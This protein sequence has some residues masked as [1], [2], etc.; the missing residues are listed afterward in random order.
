M[1]RIPIYESQVMPAG[2]PG[3][4]PQVQVI[5]TMAPAYEAGQDVLRRLDYAVQRKDEQDAVA[6]S[7]LATAETTQE[8]TK[9]ML[10]RQ[11]A[12]EPGAPNFVPQLMSDYDAW[13]EQKLEAAPNDRAR[14]AFRVRAMNLKSGLLEDGMRFQAQAGVALRRAQAQEA[15]TLYANSLVSAPGQFEAVMEEA[16]D[17]IQALDLSPIERDAMLR[18]ARG[19]LAQS[20]VAGL[21]QADPAA[22]LR[23]L[24][25]GA[26]DSYLDPGKKVAMMNAATAEM[27][28][29][30]AQARAEAA[31]ARAEFMASFQD[32]LAFLSAGGE[33]TAPT[34]YD[35][36]T[37][38]RVLGAERGRQAADAYDRALQVG[39]LR[40]DVDAMPQA[41]LD[42]LVRGLQAELMGA[43][44]EDF[45]AR[46]AH[47]ATLLNLAGERYK[48]LAADQ[49]ELASAIQAEDEAYLQRL[50]NEIDF[51]AAGGQL[52]ETEFSRQS[53]VTR[54]GDE[55]GGQ[56]ADHRDWVA[57]TAGR[58]GALAGAA[59]EEAQTAVV[60][61]RSTLLAGPQAFG[62]RSKELAAIEEAY[63]RRQKDLAA[64]PGGYA[65]RVNPAVRAAYDA[66]VAAMGDP[67]ADG[68]A[69]AERYAVV[70]SE[71][72]RRLTGQE[73]TAILP[74]AYVQNVALQFA[75]Q[76]EGGENAAQLVQG[77]QATWGKRWP[78]VYGQLVQEG[79]LPP[80]A[81]VIGSGVP[82]ATA[83]RLA[84]AS[85]LS[86]PE[87]KKGLLS[88]D[89]TALTDE[90]VSRME[91]FRLL[92]SNYAGGDAAFGPYYSAVELLGYSYMRQGSS[93]S[94]A[95]RRA[96]NELIGDRYALYDTYFVP[97]DE[98]PEEVIPSG[99]AA[100]QRDLSAW[101]PR[102]D[103]PTNMPGVPE[104]ATRAQYLSTLEAYGYW[105]TAPDQTGLVLLDP[106]GV[107]A[108][109][110]G[111]R[112]LTL[113]W[114]ELRQA[115]TGRNPLL[116]PVYPRLWG[117]P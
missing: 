82:P 76:R 46:Q 73:P 45:R 110:D 98:D 94:E 19:T 4:T 43:G 13:V 11:Q 117:M 88:T 22:A 48:G 91:D 60:A 68:A 104:E 25:D 87:L 64:D 36:D 79:A 21:V 24:R 72:L 92:L 42:A 55:L 50:Q 54:F 49:Q 29:R 40:R 61:A 44:P 35:R 97:A 59:A 14:E 83:M 112:P 100:L 30:E 16:A 1:A 115:G 90:L 101:A 105:I 116:P 37:L 33:L 26:W 57:E 107:A 12:A 32:E 106:T 86:L 66:M 69:A 15:L 38:L 41:E 93:A 27:K 39:S 51:L 103:L 71:E 53:L 20:A 6:W 96:Y 58:A 62:D 56:L 109:V 89:A 81:V 63:D 80:A 28:R 23:G 8:W 18:D 9:Q 34:R 85:R 102:L 67:N 70:A 7:A 2:S 113:T 78:E 75:Q 3:P 17:F 99:A 10:E 114:E 31:A 95:A 47:A 111:G 77:L 65:I 108:T 52:A 5:D 74:A 84:E